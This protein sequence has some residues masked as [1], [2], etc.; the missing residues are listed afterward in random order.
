MKKRSLKII[1]ILGFSFVMLTGLLNAMAEDPEICPEPLGCIHQTKCQ[2]YYNVKYV[3]GSGKYCCGR[4]PVYITG[5]LCWNEPP[6][7]K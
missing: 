5:Y 6:P 2:T 7:G 1:A 3:L 4:F